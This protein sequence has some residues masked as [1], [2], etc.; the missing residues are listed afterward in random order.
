MSQTSARS[1]VQ[2]CA[3]NASVIVNFSLVYVTKPKSHVL[4]MVNI[5]VG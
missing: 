5:A 2:R 4:K 1:I 3:I